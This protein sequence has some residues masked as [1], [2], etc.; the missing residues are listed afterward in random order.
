MVPWIKEIFFYQIYANNQKI[1]NFHLYRAPSVVR[2]YG[3]GYNNETIA[4][5]IE[6]KALESAAI[7]TQL[8]ESLNEVTLKV[9]IPYIASRTSTPNCITCHTK[10][11]E[12]M[13]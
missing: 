4:T 7:Q 3:E 2:E 13:F 8:F 5:S 9:S 6:K 11:K 1:D 12:E 10:L